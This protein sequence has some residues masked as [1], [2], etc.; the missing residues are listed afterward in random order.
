MDK[1][2][3]I[4]MIFIFTLASCSFNQ[5]N[6]EK[7]NSGEII[8]KIE[9]S[10]VEISD[11]KVE[12]K[13]IE[14]SDNKMEETDKII[15]SE[16]ENKKIVVASPKDIE[17]AWCTETID[18][19]NM[20]WCSKDSKLIKPV[21]WYPN[22]FSRSK[23]ADSWIKWAY[24]DDNDNTQY[25]YDYLAKACGVIEDEWIK[26]VWHNSESCPCPAWYHIPTSK[27]FNNMFD[28]YKK[29]HINLEQEL[30]LN[31]I[32]Y[33]AWDWRNT[34]N[35]GDY[36]SSTSIK[37]GWVFWAWIFNLYWKHSKYILEN[38]LFTNNEWDAFSLRCVKD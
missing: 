24:I 21:E 32:P 14:I 17:L 2:L 11:N 15:N 10:K 36:I 13:K 18:V 9:K 19:W 22:D 31:K 8:P 7:N 23:N 30:K 12:S 4:I 29:N 27:E 38:Y 28:I 3:M 25:T 34:Y 1:K 6:N 35:Q 16:K 26:H 5:E 37:S 33:R 20:K